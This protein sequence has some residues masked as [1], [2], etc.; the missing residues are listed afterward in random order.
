MREI[1]LDASILRQLRMLHHFAPLVISERA[2]QISMEA[3][4]RIV[5]KPFAVACALPTTSLRSTR[6]LAD[7]LRARRWAW[8]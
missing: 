8:L 5:P 2:A 4:R 7:K 1:D 3:R 6:G